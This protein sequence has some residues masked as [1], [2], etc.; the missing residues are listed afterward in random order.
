MGA[1]LVDQL[2]VLP[3]STQ[4][5]SLFLV[6]GLVNNTVNFL[7][8]LLG[9]ASIEEDLVVAVSENGWGND[10]ATTAVLDQQ[11]TAVLDQLWDRTPMSY[12]GSTAW[13]SYLRAAGGRDHP[14]A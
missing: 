12:Y 6:R 8:S 7:L 2:D 10:Q 9:L 14:R 4:P 5:G 1:T 11:T 13:Q 3:G